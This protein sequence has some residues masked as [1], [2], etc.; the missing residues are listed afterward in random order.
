MLQKGCDRHSQTVVATTTN[1]IGQRGQEV[2][3]LCSL[4][5]FRSSDALSTVRWLCLTRFFATQLKNLCTSS[6]FKSCLLYR[7]CRRRIHGRT[8]DLNCHTINYL[9]KQSSLTRGTE[10]LR[11]Q[12]L[13]RSDVL[14]HSPAMD[15]HYLKV[16]SAGRARP[17]RL[18]LSRKVAA[19]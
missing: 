6:A 16:Y 14:K 19:L 15:E 7:S 13:G 12:Q 5:I 3:E 1:C 8:A 11:S 9:H 4:T 10:K 18:T 2:V 17:P